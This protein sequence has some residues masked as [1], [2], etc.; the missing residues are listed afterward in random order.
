MFLIAYQVL[1][2]Y[3]TTHA[4][5]LY[6]LPTNKRFHLKREEKVVFY[7]L[8]PYIHLV[9]ICTSATNSKDSL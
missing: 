6:S 5:V 4:S 1:Q 8:L 2:I 9:L 3:F 7:V